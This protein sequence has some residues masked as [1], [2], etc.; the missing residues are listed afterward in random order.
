MWRHC[1]LALVLGACA[2]HVGPTGLAVGGP[3]VDTF[4]CVAGSY[5]LL[6]PEFPNGTCT[7]NC[8][9]ASDCRSPSVCIELR[10]GS[11]LLPCET[12]EDC[13]REGY[14]CRPRARAGT[15]EDALICIGG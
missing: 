11:C 1:L 15:A 14:G 6:G 3:C 4:D 12:D 9:A 7:T 8:A 10:A 5:C 13:V 2:N